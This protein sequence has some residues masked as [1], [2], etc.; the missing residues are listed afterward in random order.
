MYVHD[1]T[2]FVGPLPLYPGSRSS[3]AAVYL[4][5]RT[6]ARIGGYIYRAENMKTGNQGTS[7]VNNAETTF[8]FLP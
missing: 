4:Y 2:N 1:K 6:R 7:V 8:C 5:E 3:C